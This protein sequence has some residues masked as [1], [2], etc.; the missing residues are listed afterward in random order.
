M[1][2]IPE[3]IYD[4]EKEYPEN[5]I[6]IYSVLREIHTSNGRKPYDHLRL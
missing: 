3:M 2:F 6:K 5:H 4:S 1:T